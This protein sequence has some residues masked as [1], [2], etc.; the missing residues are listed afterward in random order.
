MSGHHPISVRA[1]R[2]SR[3]ETVH[4]V[5][6]RGLVRLEL[7]NLDLPLRQ[8]EHHLV[9]PRVRP[10][11]ARDRGRLGELVADALA[12]QNGGVAIVLRRQGERRGNKNQESERV[13]WGGRNRG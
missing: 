13:R 9:R 10:G 6:R 2:Q 3:A 8:P 11:H 4:V 12:L 5:Q 7:A 1:G